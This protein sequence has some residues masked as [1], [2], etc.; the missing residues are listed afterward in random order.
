LL[1]FSP[2]IRLAEV[3][4]ETGGY[5]PFQNPFLIWKK[6]LTLAL[7]YGNLQIYLLAILTKLFGV[8]NTGIL[9]KAPEALEY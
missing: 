4:L 7:S 8:Y 3:F 6:G 1:G 2:N 5:Y 9:Q